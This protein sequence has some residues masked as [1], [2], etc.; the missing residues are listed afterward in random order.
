MT[1]DFDG[2]DTA[3]FFTVGELARYLSKLPRSTLVAGPG[4]FLEVSRN[5]ACGEH[6]LSFCECVDE[7]SDE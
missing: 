6:Y 3:R 2:D 4:G 1:G 5:L 7:D